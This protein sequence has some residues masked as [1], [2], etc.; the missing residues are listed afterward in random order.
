MMT[1]MILEVDAT[2]QTA[3]YV[4]DPEAH[5]TVGLVTTCVVESCLHVRVDVL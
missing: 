1:V 2:Q 4:Y 5:R 3:T